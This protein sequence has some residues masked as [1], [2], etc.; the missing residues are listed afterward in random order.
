MQIS[1]YSNAPKVEKT[2]MTGENGVIQ[3]NFF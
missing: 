3:F 2:G 1:Q